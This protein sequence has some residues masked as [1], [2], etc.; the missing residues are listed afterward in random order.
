VLVLPFP[1]GG[2][3]TI[4]ITPIPEEELPEGP[5]PGTAV[6]MDAGDAT[7]NDE[8]TLELTNSREGLTEEAVEPRVQRK[9]AHLHL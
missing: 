3:A 1:L 9:H 7:F 4:S 5:L 2:N 6:E 8:V